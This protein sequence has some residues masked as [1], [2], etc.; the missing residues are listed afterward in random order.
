MCPKCLGFQDAPFFKKININININGTDIFINYII[1]T[2]L[3]ANTY[4]NQ[5]RLPFSNF[6]LETIQLAIGKKGIHLINITRICKLNWI[7]YVQS[8][9]LF[10]LKGPHFHSN[11]SKAKELICNQLVISILSMQRTSDATADELQWATKYI[12]NLPVSNHYEIIDCNNFKD[13]LD[14]PEDILSEVDIKLRTCNWLPVGFTIRYN[15]STY[16][17]SYIY[18]IQNIFH[19]RSSDDNTFKNTMLIIEK[20]LKNVI[21]NT[22]LPVSSELQKWCTTY[23]TLF[24]C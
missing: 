23:S 17:L 13:N 21:E 1:M 9:H 16:S 8:D 18:R 6:S 14:I 15:Q 5:L 2:T 12:Q 4:Y 10:E 11:F 24:R 22:T 3:F 20:T 7:Y 19:I